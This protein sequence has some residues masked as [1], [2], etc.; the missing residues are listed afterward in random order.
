[1]GKK[2]AWLLVTVVWMMGSCYLYSQVPAL[3]DA[4]VVDLSMDLAKVILLWG[5]NGL[6]CLIQAIILGDN[7]AS[8]WWTPV[9]NGA[10]FIFGSMFLAQM[11]GYEGNE[12]E[13]FVYAGA[14][15]AVTLVGLIIGAHRWSFGLER[16]ARSQEPGEYYYQKYLELRSGSGAANGVQAALNNLFQSVDMGYR[17]AVDE[18]NGIDFENSKLPEEMKA[19]GLQLQKVIESSPPESMYKKLITPQERKELDQSF[20]EKKGKLSKQEKAEV[21]KYHERATAIAERINQ[22]RATPEEAR[23]KAKDCFALYDA[24]KRGEYVIKDHDIA[25]E[26]LYGAVATDRWYK[27]ASDELWNIVKLFS[28][29]LPE[30]TLERAKKIHGL[31]MEIGN[32]EAMID[33]CEGMKE[34]APEQFE[35]NKDHYEKALRNA[36]LKWNELR[37]LASSRYVHVTLL[38]PGMSTHMSEED[39]FWEYRAKKSPITDEDKKRISEY[40]EKIK[41]IESG[42]DTF[43]DR[44]EGY[45]VLSHAYRDG[46]Y[47]IPSKDNAVWYL[48]MAVIEGSVK[49]ANELL[50]DYIKVDGALSEDMLETANQIHSGGLDIG[51][52]QWAADIWQRVKEESPE[53]YVQEKEDELREAIAQE[54]ERLRELI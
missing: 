6:F 32:D 45:R 48:L 12:K 7:W 29:G 20:W 39:K 52:L 34:H 40:R 43:K 2:G 36:P 25:L 54:R 26:Y 24:Y 17:K 44:G 9:G 15:A 42:V 8:W 1:M 47:V 38:P 3:I 33:L 46:E 5:A 28:S 23:K 13:I 18:L 11:E 10:A 19:K 37:C 51:R 49:A 35:R 50:E 27:E 16:A 53:F 30:R 14:Y 21:E 41:T 4:G 31:W 22:Y